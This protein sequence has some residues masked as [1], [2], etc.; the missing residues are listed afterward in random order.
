MD[1]AGAAS[2]SAAMPGFVLLR[3]GALPRTT[4]SKIQRFFCR[5]RYLSGQLSAVVT[6]GHSCPARVRNAAN[7][8]V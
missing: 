5:D 7:E 1:P 8:T 2:A 3:P 6:V 4:S